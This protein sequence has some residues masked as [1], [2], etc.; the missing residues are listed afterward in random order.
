MS[1]GSERGFRL[2]EPRDVDLPDQVPPFR[3]H[4]SAR[5][6][7][8][9]PVLHL[10]HLDIPAGDRDHEGVAHVRRGLRRD[11]VLEDRRVRRLGHPPEDEKVRLPARYPGA[12]RFHRGWVPSDGLARRQESTRWNDKA[13]FGRFSELI[14]GRNQSSNQAPQEQ[15]TASEVTWTPHRGHANTYSLAPPEGP[16]PRHGGWIRR[17]GRARPGI[18]FIR[19][20]PSGATREGGAAVL[21]AIE[22]EGREL[23]ALPTQD[24]R[25]RAQIRH[26]F[27]DLGRRVHILPHTPLQRHE[28][29][30]LESSAHRAFVPSPI[31]QNWQTMIIRTNSIRTPS[32]RDP[33]REWFK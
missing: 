5:L 4:R 26:A 13:L 7:A 14:L 28:D 10:I 9:V 27:V 33:A 29:H 2:R 20:D 12:F 17:G 6:V 23:A 31:R 8:A 22:F 11:L 21:A 18:A 32:A 19:V 16:N 24:P 30:A 3:G 15:R 1:S 25:H